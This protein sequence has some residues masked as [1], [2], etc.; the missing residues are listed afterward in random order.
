[1]HYYVVYYENDIIIPIPFD[2]KEDADNYI[3]KY[4]LHAYITLF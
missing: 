2:R 1:M 3:F 4:H